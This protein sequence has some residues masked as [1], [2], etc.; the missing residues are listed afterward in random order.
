M[1]AAVT[2]ALLFTA[3][4]EPRERPD[5]DTCPN[6]LHPCGITDQADP[7][8]H[9]KLIEREGWDLNLCASCHGADFSGGPSGVTCLT[10]H[11]QGPTACDTCHDTPP[12][13]GAHAKHAVACTT[14]HVVPERWDAEGH[15]RLAGA[16]DPPPAE[17]A[18]SGLAAVTLDPADRAGPP[19]WDHASGTCANVYCHGDVLG[20]GAAAITRPSWSGGPAQAACGTCHGQPPAS[21]AQDLCVTCHPADAPHVDGTI[22]V[23]LSL[24]CAGC[25]GDATSPAPP[26]GLLGERL[27]G[28]LAVGAHR[29]HLDGRHRLRGPLECSSCHVVPSQID[30]AGHID[31]PVPAEVTMVDGAWD[32][33]AATCSGT[34]CHGDATPVWTRVGLS[35]I[36]CGTCHGIP[37]ATPL[38][39]P[40][41]T[42]SDCV[43]CHPSTVD[44]FGNILLGGPPGRES[45]H[46]D[47]NVDF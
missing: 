20:D 43:S 32:R 44:G 19:A 42:I 26:R 12:A 17:V 23:G 34:W 11:Q 40:A 39:D 5:A 9:G 25:H 3:C 1:R 24:G 13:T 6:T 15:V 27:T 28:E 47:G 31:T 21:H 22:T 8:F 35:E 37:P 41:L 7:E 16:A 38:H 45:E 10:C 4:S 36:A 18:L 14:C 33:A 29:S 30:D 2:L 46:M